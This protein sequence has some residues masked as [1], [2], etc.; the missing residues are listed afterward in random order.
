MKKVGVKILR[1][2]EL[3]IKENLVLKR[4]KVYVLKDKE[5]RIEIIWLY[6]NIPIVEHKERWKMIELVTKN[7]WWLEV[8]KDVRKYVDRC[9]LC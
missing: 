7:Y 2:E 3:Q 5:L 8:I 6:H 1:D 9:K 4:G